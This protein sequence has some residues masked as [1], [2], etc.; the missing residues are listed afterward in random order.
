MGIKISTPS[1]EE[2]KQLQPNTT[3]KFRRGKTRTTQKANQTRTKPHVQ[4]GIICKPQEISH[5]QATTVQHFL[6]SLFS[7]TVLLNNFVI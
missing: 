6:P 7:L 1:Q 4:Y 3:S 2:K 5:H